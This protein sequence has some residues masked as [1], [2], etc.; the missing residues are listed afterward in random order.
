MKRVAYIHQYFR[1]PEEGGAIRSFYIS[2]ALVE[3]GCQ[4]EIITAHNKREYELKLIHGLKVHYLPVAYNN[5]FGFFKRIYA[6]LK[7]TV[8]AISR[9]KK[10]KKP[11]VCYATSTPLTVG[12]IALWCKKQIGIPYI[13]EIRDLWPEAP[14]QLR[15]IKG[16]VTKFLARKLEAMFYQN[17]SQLVALSP[18]IEE[19]IKRRFPELPVSTIPN[20][21]DCQYFMPTQKHELLIQEHD[22]KNK[23]V[24]A[25][26]GAIGRVN[27]LEY[28]LQAANLFQKLDDSVVFLIAGDGAQ[29]KSLEQLASTYQLKNVRFLGHLNREGVRN[30]LN[31]TDAA[32]ISFARHKVL[33]TNSPNKFFDALA[34]GKL[35]ITN[36]SGWVRQ[37]VEAHHCGLYYNPNRPE[38]LMKFIQQ[39]QSDLKELRVYQK[40]A[41]MLAE[42]Y[43]DREKLTGQLADLITPGQSDV[44]ITG[45][46]AYISNR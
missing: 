7:F 8:L 30:M 23:F 46:K 40:N 21:S 5:N 39:I 15:I 10:I 32:Y 13:F 11:D 26:F 9:L 19:N 2:Q 28:M 29:R 25:Y 1:T 37:L 44:K 24:I 4:V 31:V 38:E 12:L 6:F 35:I 43:F 17:A 27:Q 45:E 33:E 22:V 16:S 14:I 34:A 41:R 3:R 42:K 20:M 18:G 36:T